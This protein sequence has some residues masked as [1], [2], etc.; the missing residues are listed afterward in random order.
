MNQSLLGYWVIKHIHM[1]MSQANSLYSYL[2]QT[3]MPFC[4]VLQNWRT[5]RHRWLMHVILAT[6]KTE[7]R[8]IVVQSQPG[9]IVH[10]T[11][12]QKKII[13][14]DWWSGLRCRP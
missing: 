12:C 8:R 3:N 6:Q 11:L 10:K 9:Q 5:A 13:K 7:L 2:I 1:E 4:F 14:K